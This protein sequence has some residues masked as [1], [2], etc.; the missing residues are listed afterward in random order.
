MD[1]NGTSFSNVSNESNEWGI[2][3]LCEKFSVTSIDVID[4]IKAVGN[5]KQDIEWYLSKKQKR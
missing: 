4:A 2:H 1:S 3:Y 5:S